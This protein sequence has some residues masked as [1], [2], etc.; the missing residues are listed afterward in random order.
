MSSLEK[1]LLSV[2]NESTNNDGL[3]STCTTTVAKLAMNLKKI[4]WKKVCFIRKV[5]CY[6]FILT[7]WIAIFIV[8][9][10]DVDNNYEYKSL[11]YT[12]P[13]KIILFGDSLMN[14]GYSY[15]NL[16]EKLQ[17]QFP[18]VSLTIVNSGVNGDKIADMKARMYTDVVDQHPD[19]VLIYWDSDVSDLSLEI[20]EVIV[21][22]MCNGITLCVSFNQQY[23]FACVVMF[24]ISIIYVCTNFR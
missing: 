23:D 15:Y 24:P 11:T 22:F 21:H 7:L 5:C 8:S 10:P 2:N 18:Y 20:I 4:N 14:V 19:A 12:K 9:Y 6:V 1:S 16:G 13:F 17:H 3:T